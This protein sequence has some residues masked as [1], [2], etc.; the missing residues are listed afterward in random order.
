[1][2]KQLTIMLLILLATPM[3]GQR[4]AV[5]ENLSFAALRVPNIGMEAKVGDKLTLDVSAAYNPFQISETKKWKLWTI[6]P[7]LRYWFC[8]EFAGS[9]VGFHVG[10]GQFNMG[11]FDAATNLSSLGGINFNDLKDTRMQ[12]T[13]WNAGFS[14]GHQ[15]VLSS[16][17]SLEGTIGLGFARYG[18]VRYRCLH[19]GERIE[20][21]TKNYLGPTRASISLVYM[22]R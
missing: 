2:R 7:E 19:C 9:F 12:G 14:Y 16:H 13:F 3:G 8:E 15:Y 18:Y 1:M 10:A 17:W 11:G 5:K 22:I 4:L 6:Q 21:G 20:E